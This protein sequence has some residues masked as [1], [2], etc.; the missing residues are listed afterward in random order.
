MARLGSIVRACD[1]RVVRRA[2]VHQNVR[3]LKVS[4]N[5]RVGM[6][7]AQARDDLA[8]KLL[9]AGLAEGAKL[10]Y[11]RGDRATGDILHPNDCFV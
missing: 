11:Q 6:Q 8:R 9:D 5:N 2:E 3:R 1:G 4:M 10:F 7:I